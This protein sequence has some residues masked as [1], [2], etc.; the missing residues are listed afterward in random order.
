LQVEEIYDIVQSIG[1]DRDDRRKKQSLM[2]QMRDAVLGISDI[3]DDFLYFSA[4]SGSDE[5]EKQAR[6]MRKNADSLL[7]K[8]AISRFGEA[9]QPLDPALHSVHAAEPS[10]CPYEHIVTVLQCGYRCMGA[11]VRKAS[12]VVSTGEAGEDQPAATE[13]PEKAEEQGT[14]E[15]ESGEQETEEHGEKGLS[16][17][18]KKRFRRKPRF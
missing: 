17:W 11:V 3:I 1:E 6:M 9:G 5:L 14:V 2:D 10:A 12:V 7:E 4:Q 8:C 18:F 15:Q 16:G 13:T